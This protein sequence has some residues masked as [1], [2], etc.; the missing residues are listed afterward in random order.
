VW[1]A[2]RL[3]RNT[4]AEV[5]FQSGRRDD[6]VAE[7]KKCIEQAPGRQYYRRQLKRM[8]EDTP[9]TEPSDPE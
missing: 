7:M 9:I 2:V 3:H 8:Q 6:A 4:L 5:L 1:F